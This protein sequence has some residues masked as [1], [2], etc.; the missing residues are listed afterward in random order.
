MQHLRE[1]R[2]FVEVDELDAAIIVSGIDCAIRGIKGQ[3][4]WSG[5]EQ[6]RVQSHAVGIVPYYDS[7]VF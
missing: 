4:K 1:R 2:L 6:V 5:W 3:T 7:I